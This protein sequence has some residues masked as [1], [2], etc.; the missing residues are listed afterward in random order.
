MGHAENA[1]SWTLRPATAFERL[2]AEHTLTHVQHTTLDTH[3]RGNG[4]LNHAIPD[5]RT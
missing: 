1:V 2:F 5:A 4:E 3:R